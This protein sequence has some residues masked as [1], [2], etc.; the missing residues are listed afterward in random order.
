MS[1]NYDSGEDSSHARPL[2]QTNQ[3]QI[4]YGETT[5]EHCWLYLDSNNDLWYAYGDDDSWT[6]EK[7]T[8]VVTAGILAHNVPVVNMSLFLDHNNE[9]VHIVYTDGANVFYAELTDMDD[10]GT[11]A[12]WTGFPTFKY[13]VVDNSGANDIG[14]CVITLDGNTGNGS[15]DPHVV[16]DEDTGG[17]TWEVH[18]NYGGT[19]G[20]HGFTPSSE[21]KLDD[22][23]HPTIVGIEEEGR[24]V[25][26]FFYDDGNNRVECTRLLDAAAVGAVPPVDINNWGGPVAG[27]GGGTDIT[28]T[29]GGSDT[30]MIPSASYW[31]EQGT[32]ERVGVVAA[33]TPTTDTVITNRWNEGALGGAAWDGQ[34]TASGYTGTA[35]VA[36][37]TQLQEHEWRLNIMN[38]T[39]AIYHG[40]SLGDSMDFSSGIAWFLLSSTTP[41][42]GGEFS[43]DWRDL[44]HNDAVLDY[45]RSTVVFKD[46][47]NNLWYCYA[48]ENTSKKPLL[49]DP[50]D[51]DVVAFHNE[52]EE[53]DFD[54]SFQ[55]D[56]MVG[57]PGVGDDQREYYVEIDNDI[58]F[59]SPHADPGTGLRLNT[60]VE[61]TDQV[62]TLDA[63]ELAA[64]TTYYWRV[65]TRDSQYG[66]EY[67]PESESDFATG[68]RFD[69]TPQVVATLP[70]V[71]Q[72]SDRDVYLT[73]RLQIETEDA[74]ADDDNNI[75]VLNADYDIGGG[76]VSMTNIIGEST[77]DVSDPDGIDVPVIGS[78]WDFTFAWNADADTNYPSTKI[79]QTV[80]FRFIVRY[81]SDGHGLGNVTASKT[82]VAIDFEE[83]TQAIGWPD[84][85]TI[86]TSTPT[87]EATMTDTTG[88]QVEFRLSKTDNTLVTWDTS[89]GLLGAGTDTWKVTPELDKGGL[90]YFGVIAQDT[91][92]S[93]NANSAPDAGSFTYT[94]PSDPVVCIDGAFTIEIDHLR[95][96]VGDEFAV[97]HRCMDANLSY[98]INAPHEFEF[99]LLNPG[100]IWTDS[101]SAYKIY[102]GDEVKF[103]RDSGQMFYGT[104]R[105]YNVSTDDVRTVSVH[106]E[107]FS[108]Q[109]ESYPIQAEIE[110]TDLGGYHWEDYI[111]YALRDNGLSPVWFR[112][113]NGD[114]TV[115]DPN[116]PEEE[117]VPVM[118]GNT[119]V[120]NKIALSSFL[121]NVVSRTGKIWYE[122]TTEP[123]GQKAYLYWT[124]AS[125]PLEDDTDHT[126]IFENH[127][128]SA[129]LQY[130][131][132][133]LINCV[134]Y[135]NA[136][137]MEQDMNSIREYGRHTYYANSSG[138]EDIDRLVEMAQ[139]IIE[140]RKEPR[141]NGTLPIYGE[142]TDVALNDIVQVYEEGSD[143]EM[144][145]FA[146]K[147]RIVGI[148]YGY[149]TSGITTTIVLNSRY[150][151]PYIKYLIES[152]IEGSDTKADP[153][154]FL[155]AETA[156]LRVE[157]PTDGVEV[158]VEAS[159]E[160]RLGHSLYADLDTDE[161]Y[162]NEYGDGI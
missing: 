130:D 79:D 104:I 1:K 39:G 71:T 54:W 119:I 112:F 139:Y 161:D 98:K 34:N 38:T 158:S 91:S 56:E 4:D 102:K 64:A 152:N 97:Q 31:W 135:T 68:E 16:W 5:E 148:D 22:G 76:W 53:I 60:W 37:V 75:E 92:P 94:A 162:Y 10:P 89:S 29:G 141:L 99:E 125:N 48:R 128:L 144:S 57:P 67:D 109:A 126:F 106:C 150:E 49:V 7:L 65:K 51:D 134:I 87:L 58:G 55:D 26:V 61:S 93:Y 40:R 137:V 156:E 6:P 132:D 140:E 50:S 155:R 143:A 88:F 72:Q 118:A 105:E 131:M 90:W 52:L 151:N 100:G 80:D 153:I 96:W 117:K 116:T 95:K 36:M 24:T 17:S 44:E 32:G 129:S 25:Y 133:T 45:I 85:E 160:A 123:T 63:G 84:G 86:A 33:S 113:V 146:G 46:G 15:N 136:D 11:A 35:V 14:S 59:G 77:S 157:Y 115:I 18:Y 9:H 127:I 27:A 142:N 69:T 81:L 159:N 13:D 42:S 121:N 124:D 122:G 20:A 47:T 149:S 66:T 147:Y 73:L 41:D 111:W 62:G 103:T 23:M 83:P 8:S 43:C 107:S 120:E 74:D 28:L 138:I 3:R 78:T 12:K 145:G 19:G 101:S 114:G 82:N 70:T 110:A 30:I 154:V 108:G 2:G 21:I